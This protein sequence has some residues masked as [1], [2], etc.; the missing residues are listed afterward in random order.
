MQYQ[1]CEASGRENLEKLVNENIQIGW[2]PL[3]GVS[4]DHQPGL[5]GNWWY[6]QAM[7]R[8]DREDESFRR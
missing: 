5:F 2:Q 6:F 1:I 7:V 3:G 8:T 4:V